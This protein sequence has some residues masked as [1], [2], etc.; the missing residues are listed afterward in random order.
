MALNFPNP[1]RSFDASKN[2]VT[3]WGYDSVIEIS[4]S[5]EGDALL[6]NQAIDINTL[7]RRVFAHGKASKRRCST[8]T[9][10]FDNAVRE[11]THDGLS[12]K[13]HKDRGYK[14]DSARCCGS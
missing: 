12:L 5:V 7:S 8:S 11:Q 13:Y 6:T 2:R 4:F 10:S 3:F 9:A 1:S 14:R